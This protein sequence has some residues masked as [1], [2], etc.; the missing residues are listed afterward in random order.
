MA[1]RR[2]DDYKS[3]SPVCSSLCFSDALPLEL[4]SPTKWK[5][6][7]SARKDPTQYLLTVEQ[8][9]ENDYPVPSYLADVFSKPDGWIETPEA[10]PGARPGALL[11]YAIDCEMVRALRCQ[12]RIV[13]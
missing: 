9:V 5:A 13:C 11:V 3:A 4:T 1:R 8:M 10:D 6:E 12:C 2:R 7:R